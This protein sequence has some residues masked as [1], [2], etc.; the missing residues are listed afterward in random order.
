MLPLLDQF[1]HEGPN[2][3][4]I[5]FVFDVLGHHLDFQTAKYENGRLPIKAVRTIARQLLL[6]LDFVHREC[7]IIHTGTTIRY[8][9]PPTYN[10]DTNYGRYRDLKPTNILLE[11][12]N[13]EQTIEK[14]RAEVPIRVSN[15][16]G[17]TR[18]LREVIRTPLISEIREPHIRIFDS[19]VYMYN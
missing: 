16:Y 11:L 10:N 1:K 9:L 17:I 5:C 15:E 4:H 3:Q 14:H 2:G 18:P 13:P 6:G 7:R 8:E 12:E 19:S